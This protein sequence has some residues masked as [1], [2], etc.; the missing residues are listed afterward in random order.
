MELF[1]TA[2]VLDGH[3]K[4]IAYH[5]SLKHPSDMIKFMNADLT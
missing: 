1:S 3:V 2:G 4:R 5:N